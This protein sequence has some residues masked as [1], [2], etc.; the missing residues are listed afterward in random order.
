MSMFTTCPACR[1]NL[2]VT[3]TDLRIGQGYVRCGRCHRVFNALLTLAEDLDQEE[4]GLAAT[5]TITVPAL[6]DPDEEASP[7]EVVI[8]VGDLEEVDVVDVLRAGDAVTAPPADPPIENDPAPGIR[9][10]GADKYVVD[11]VE[12]QATG[13]FE[14]IVLEGDGFLQTEE[15]VD[16]EEVDAQLQEL[17]RQMDTQEQNPPAEDIV[18]ETAAAEPELDADAAVGN[19]RRHHWIWWA[20][21]LLLALALGGQLVHHS[22]QTLV[23]HPVLGRPLQSLYALFGVKLEPLWDLDAYEVRQLGGEAPPGSAD[24]IT[25]RASIHNRAT[26]SQPPPMIR[27]VLQDRY[28]NALSTTDIAPA[29][30]LREPPERIGPDQRLDVLL[31]VAD[32]THQAAGFELDA[33]LP[34]ADGRIHCSNGS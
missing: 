16:E 33:C 1:M 30:Y 2:A 8:E 6:E 32:P 23:S 12:S 17:A 28:G 13:T 22:R 31:T 25:L 11:V 14:T 9:R 15:H 18:L 34:G 10:P 19:R 27:V 20:A 4:P 3:P 26:M 24:R 5:G 7:E 29:A 21:A